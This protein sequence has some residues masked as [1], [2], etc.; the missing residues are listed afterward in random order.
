M[1][2]LDLEVFELTIIPLEI[3]EEAG[4]ITWVG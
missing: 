3:D 2:V 4:I 1:G